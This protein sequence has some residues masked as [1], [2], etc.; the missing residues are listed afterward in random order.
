MRDDSRS[1][2]ARFKDPASR[3][4]EPTDKE[5]ERWQEL[6]ND[7]NTDPD[8]MR[9]VQSHRSH[10]SLAESGRRGYAATARKYGRDFAADILAAHRRDNPSGPEQALIGLLRELGYEAN[11]DYLR[12]HKLEPGVYSDFAWPERKLAIEVHGSAHQAEFFLG[13]GMLE[14]EIGRSEAYDRKGW[15]VVVVTG[16]QLLDEMTTT[17]ERIQTL[18]NGHAPNGV[19]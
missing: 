14:R 5:R 11:R 15:R 3:P 13:N 17:R 18:L 16:D 12:E 7:R 19:L 8:Y 2:S 10:E 4:L 6:G 9:Y 1:G